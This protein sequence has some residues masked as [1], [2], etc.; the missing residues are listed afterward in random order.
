M[1]FNCFPV[2]IFIGVLCN[3]LMTQYIYHESM[4]RKHGHKE[5]KLKHQPNREVIYK[6]TELD[7]SN[8]YKITRDMNGDYAVIMF[9]FY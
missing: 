5:F 4:N 9:N 1:H 2:H 6:M 8:L 3:L 7:D